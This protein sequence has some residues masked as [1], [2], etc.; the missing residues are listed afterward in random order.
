MRALHSNIINCFQSGLDRAC[1]VALRVVKS[2]S[3]RALTKD[4]GLNTPTLDLVIIK[5]SLIVKLL[6]G[7]FDKDDWI[8]D[9]SNKCSMGW[10]SKEMMIEYEWWYF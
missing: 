1:L 5:W 6:E 7:D 2:F 3:I 10:H 9:K 8:I 4:F